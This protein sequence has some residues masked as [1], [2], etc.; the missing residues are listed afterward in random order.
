MK[1]SIIKKQGKQGDDTTS[2]PDEPLVLAEVA[3]DAALM[4]AQVG[5]IVDREVYESL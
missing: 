5:G 2:V 1:E 3:A 4:V